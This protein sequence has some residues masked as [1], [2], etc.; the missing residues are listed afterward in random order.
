MALAMGPG[1]RVF[2]TD[3]PTLA[4]SADVCGTVRADQKPDSAVNNR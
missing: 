4:R 1:Y 2:C 3:C